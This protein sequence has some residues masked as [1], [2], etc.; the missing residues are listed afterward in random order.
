LLLENSADAAGQPLNEDQ[1]V[2]PAQ[3]QV[4]A[5]QRALPE[6]VSLDHSERRAMS[7]RNRAIRM[8]DAISVAAPF[9]DRKAKD[10]Q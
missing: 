2:P 1:Q 9:L 6:L 5:F 3:D 7:R 8:I 4:A 10:T